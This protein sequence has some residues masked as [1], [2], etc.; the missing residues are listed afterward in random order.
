[1]HFFYAKISMS[2]N[3][4]NVKQLTN[5]KKAITILINLLKDYIKL[6]LEKEYKHLSN[7]RCLF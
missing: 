3:L 5:I 4:L 1:M 6:Y 2:V 7:Y